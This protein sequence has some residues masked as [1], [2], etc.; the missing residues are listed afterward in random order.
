M[1]SRN[2][3]QWYRLRVFCAFSSYFQLQGVLKFVNYLSVDGIFLRHYDATFT[4]F[5]LFVELGCVSDRKLF[6]S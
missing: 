4:C 6:T 2:K 3:L 5:P 1:I